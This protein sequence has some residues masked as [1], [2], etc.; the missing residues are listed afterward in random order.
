MMSWP[1]VNAEPRRDGLA[2]HGRLSKRR[3]NMSF[4]SP[5]VAPARHAREE[6]RRRLPRIRSEQRLDRVLKGTVAEDGHVGSPISVPRFEPSEPRCDPGHEFQDRLA[7][8]INGLGDE[9]AA[10]V[11]RRSLRVGVAA[12]GSKII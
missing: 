6:L 8:A 7:R 12:D 11:L 1:H 3:Q 2:R 4:S 9:G 5:Q 10:T